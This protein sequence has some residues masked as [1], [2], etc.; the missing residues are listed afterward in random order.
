MQHKWQN[1]KNRHRRLRLL[2]ARQLT[3]P[4][5][6]ITGRTDPVLAPRMERAGIAAVLAKPVGDEELV[7]AIRSAGSAGAR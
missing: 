3:T 5:I 4:V 2:R 1:K 6:I 7:G